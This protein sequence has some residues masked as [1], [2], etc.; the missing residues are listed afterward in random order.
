LIPTS[1][2]LNI[3]IAFAFAKNIVKLVSIYERYELSENEFISITILFN[4]AK[5]KIQFHLIEKPPQL[6]NFQ[7]FQK[8]ILDFNETAIVSHIINLKKYEY[9]DSLPS[10]HLK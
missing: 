10:I 1:E 3:L 9:K 7:I 5:M 8:D 6:T 2:M 4:T